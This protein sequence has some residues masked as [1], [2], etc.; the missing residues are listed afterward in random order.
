MKP[1]YLQKSSQSV[2]RD[3]RKSQPACRRVRVSR[4]V[5]GKLRLLSL[6]CLTV[7][8]GAQAQP[9]SVWGQVWAQAFGVWTV[10]SLTSVPGPGVYTLTLAA[11]TPVEIQGGPSLQPLSVDAPLW[12]DDGSNREEATPLE[13]HCSW[14]PGNCTMTVQ[15][16]MSHR[17]P[18]NVRSATGGLQEAIDYLRIR[19]GTVNVAPGWSG[20]TAMITAAA[21]ASNVQIHDER[22]GASV[23]YGWD[24]AAYGPLMATND[25]AAQLSLSGGGTVRGSF[26]ISAGSVN[27]TLSAAGFGAVSSTAASSGTMAAGSTELA[28]AAAQ[29]FA[30][31]QGILVARAGSGVA[32]AKPAS[33]A[34]AGTAVTGEQQCKYSIAALDAN[35]GETAASAA[36]PAQP[37]GGVGSSHN[38]VITSYNVLTWTPVDQARGYVV[39]EN[40]GSQYAVA[41]IVGIPASVP[42][43]SSGTPVRTGQKIQPRGAQYNG[44]FYAATTAGITGSVQ[45]DW[46]TTVGCTVQDG[47][48]TWTAQP[49]TWHD[50]GRNWA[51]FGVRPEIPTIPGSPPASALADALVTTVLGVGSTGQLTL[52]APAQAAVSGAYVAHDNSA[53]LNAAMAAQAAACQAY[54]P[55]PGSTYTGTCPVLQFPSGHYVISQPLTSS[56]AYADLQGSSGATLEQINPV[57]DIF[58]LASPG[59][60]PQ[61]GYLNR[62]AGFTLVGGWH[63]IFDGNDAGADAMQTAFTFDEFRMAHDYAVVA[64]NPINNNDLH[65]SS[66]ISL[67]HSR[68]QDNVALVYE[69]G[70]RFYLD[71]DWMEFLGWTQSNNWDQALIVN[72]ETG[73]YM[74][75]EHDEGIPGLG[76]PNGAAGGRPAQLRW[77]DDFW[78]LSLA[79]DRFSAEGGGGIPIVYYQGGF[80]SG[81]YGLGGAVSFLDG[82]YYGG[83]SNFGGGLSDA[84][85]LYLAYGMPS[86]VQFAGNA[87]IGVDEPY[88][89][90]GQGASLEYGLWQQLRIAAGESDGGIFGPLGALS[91]SLGSG[92]RACTQTNAAA[93][94]AK[95]FPAALLAMVTQ[96]QCRTATVIPESGIWTQGQWLRNAAPG[97]QAPPGWIVQRS[98]LAAAAWQPNTSY[99]P[100]TFVETQPDNGHVFAVTSACSSGATQPSWQTGTGA[101][102][103]DGTCSWSEAG[104]AALFAPAGLSMSATGQGAIAAL[105]VGT[106]NLDGGQL[107]VHAGTNENLV[108]QGGVDVA[109]AAAISSRNDSQNANVPLELRA[110][111]FDFR[112]GAAHF[113]G[114]LSDDGNINVAQHYQ[115]NGS[116]LGFADLAGSAGCTQMPA[117]TGDLSTAA[118]TCA[119]TVTGA[120]GAAIPAAALLLG[121]NSQAQLVGSATT[122]G[123]MNTAL[124]S[125]A[126]AP[127]VASGFGTGAT[128]SAS[129][130]PSAFRLTVGSGSSSG[131]IGL[132]A[133]AHGWNCYATDETAPGSNNTRISA[134]TTTTVTLS[135]F[136]PSGALTPWA[137]GDTLAVSCFAY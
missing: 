74:Y 3:G 67:E 38:G 58:D 14:S 18:F 95:N 90:N 39:Y 122:N 27:G 117:L 69:N 91:L 120:H 124:L 10:Q 134:D 97:L 53:A 31:G 105:G 128:V 44:W 16:R 85:T 93:F 30:V 87:Q 28:L 112:L 83:Q 1:Q 11:N 29:D 78:D 65:L 33:P 136:N 24:G 92:Y 55:M 49:F 82:W 59:T 89:E 79:N 113:A 63:Q 130:G 62:I 8:A 13:V 48:V 64:F 72:A 66:S 23:W 46:C 15:L 32:L 132:P 40:T 109:G 129:N 61:V 35:L 127:T 131:T 107:A 133:A 2:A 94:T 110:S 17:A 84:S 137:A 104:Q 102:T 70:D 135:N 101:V 19:G 12:I 7:A 22:D 75:I 108:V 36:T 68:F 4:G 25:P 88:V 123:G 80:P 9:W 111:E 125:S 116:N 43:W 34:V 71:H 81:P 126:A 57:A 41:G 119:A 100:D 56:S 21:G 99:A 51:W 50:D 37:C 52:A 76:A 106:T 60:G 118:G 86:I 5:G 42:W 98:G 121:T 20:E 45:P 96:D 54:K 103:S 114:D 47:G 73:G 26:Q 77:I 6:L 115:V